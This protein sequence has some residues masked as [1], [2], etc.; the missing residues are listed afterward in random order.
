MVSVIKQGATVTDQRVLKFFADYIEIQLGI[1]YNDANYFQLEHRLKNIAAQLGMKAVE[2]LHAKAI[3]G[4]EGNLR[5]FLLD[6]ATNNETS[7]FRDPNIYKALSGFIIPETIKSLNGNTVQIWSAASSSGQEVYSIAMEY[8]AAK[9][10]N[11]SWP[12]YAITATDIS[13]TILKRAEQGIYSQLEV[14]RGLPAKKLID[15][16]AK[17]S[18]NTWRVKDELKAKTSFKKLN[19]LENWTGM[20]PFHIVFCRNVLIYQN[21]DNKKKVVE[22]IYS[23]LNPHGFLVMGAAESLFGINE[24]FEQISFSGSVFYRKK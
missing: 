22:K 20:G 24:N 14:Q 3:R 13:D 10:A 21:V 19:L 5:N 12:D 8:D 16:F 18:D 4:I 1:I 6:L 9:K 2:E 7:F 23:I 17:D 15:H 11:P